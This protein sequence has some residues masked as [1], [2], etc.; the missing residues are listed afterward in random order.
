VEGE[1]DEV[2]L[3]A[4][5]QWR[6]SPRATLKLNNGFGLTNKAPDQAPEIG[7]ALSF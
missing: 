3:I 7:I 6:L 2:A 1:Q 4:E 5:L